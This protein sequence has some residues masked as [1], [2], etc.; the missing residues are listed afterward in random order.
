MDTIPQKKRCSKCRETKA[1]DEFHRCSAKP[2]GHLARCK[3][4]RAA[5]PDRTGD[6]LSIPARFWAK[7]DKNGPTHPQ[8]GTPCW[9]WI[10]HRK[11]SGYGTFNIGPRDYVASRVAYELHH[12]PIPAGMFVCHHCDNPPCVN[13]D[14][15][16]LGTPTDN[17]RDMVAKRRHHAAV[18][19]ETMP[20]GERH[21]RAK[22]DW[23]K[24]AEIRA[25]YAV[26]GTTHRE[27]ALRYGVSRIAVLKVVR[28]QSWTHR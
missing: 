8:L 12:G 1:L 6:E 23:G 19:P 26:G 27:L 5:G 24:V 15:L 3:A 17:G 16:F 9:L 18:S 25:R 2:D 22:L 4:C 21:G 13:P 14:H 10:A 20:R 11:Q 28:G 7:V